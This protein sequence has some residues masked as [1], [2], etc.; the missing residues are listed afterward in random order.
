MRVR[1]D[2]VGLR[3]DVEL[4]H[5]GVPSSARRSVA[6]MRHSHGPRAPS[7]RT[8]LVVSPCQWVSGAGADG[9]VATP[10]WR[11]R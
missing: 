11:I 2:H 3:D 4:A 5:A 8:Q 7:R 9:L 6:R 1:S 10:T